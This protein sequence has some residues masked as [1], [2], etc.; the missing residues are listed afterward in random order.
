MDR[1]ELEN[2]LIELISKTLE[3]PRE[4]IKPESNFADDLKVDSLGMVDLLMALEDELQITI[5]DEEAE[6]IKTVSEAIDLVA[7]KLGA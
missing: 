5:P 7:S 1:A 4:E 2:K 6:N 3:I